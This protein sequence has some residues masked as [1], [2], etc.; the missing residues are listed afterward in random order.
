MIRFIIGRIILQRGGHLK[1]K[2]YSD[3][4]YLPHGTTYVN[5][6]WPFWGKLPE[7]PGAIDSGRFD[8]YTELG[9]RF[10][11]MT[12]LAEADVAVMPADWEPGEYDPAPLLAFADQARQADKPLAIFFWGDSFDEVPFEGAYIFRTSFLRSL[13][14]PT[15][16]SVPVWSEDFIER[17]QDGKLPVR[18]KQ[19]R[20]TVGFCGFADPL[21]PA[22][23][24]R[25]I[26]LARRAKAVGTGRR[27]NKA[28]GVLGRA[29]RGKA[30]RKLD[31][32]PLVDT[33]FVI[34]DRFWAGAVA[35]GWQTDPAAQRTARR[36]YVQNMIDSDYTLCVRGAGNFSFR[37][38]ETLCSGRI[39]VFIDTDSML[40]YDFAVDWKQYCVWVDQREIDQ[41][42]VKVAAF[43]E[44]LSPQ[45]FI[46][47][48][49][50]C[51][52][53]WQEWLSP[54]GFFGNF[55]RHFGRG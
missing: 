5:L 37:L 22:L 51:R 19:P 2:I 23:R 43:H 10:F 46:D 33:N 24:H 8:R 38:Y 9:H 50:E 54:E 16:F 1:L 35:P 55:Y 26:N 12:P 14:K 7:D 18:Q 52:K 17:Y 15:E 13:H 27:G 47:L 41:I 6:L 49:H 44:S 31:R 30:L 53:F 34:R 28:A 40:P 48:Q 20:P 39:P 29:I 42:G 36:D 25:L 3:R 11:K 4:H 32:S 45:E 21:R